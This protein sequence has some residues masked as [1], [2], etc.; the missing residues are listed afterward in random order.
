MRVP[1]ERIELRPSFQ[2]RDSA[3]GWLAIRIKGLDLEAVEALYVDL[4]DVETL[5]GK[6]KD[7]ESLFRRLA[8]SLGDDEA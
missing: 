4:A 3:A 2:G 6:Q 8:E 7:A 1:R 5:R